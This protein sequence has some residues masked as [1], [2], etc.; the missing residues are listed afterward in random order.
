[1]EVQN[2]LMSHLKAKKGDFI[3][4]ATSLGSCIGLILYDSEN[5]IGGMAHIML[6]TSPLVNENN[7]IE[8]D[9]T[10][11]RYANKAIPTLIKEMKML[12]SKEN[13]ITAMLF[14]GSEMFEHIKDPSLKIGQ[15][16]I[17]KI[18]EIL[19]EINIPIV[20]EDT[21]G[22]KGRSVELN[23]FNGKVSLND[24]KIGQKTV[25]FVI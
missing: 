24:F 5:K 18:K 4:R 16:N 19:S 10:L 22:K 11:G 21:G 15:K 13:N 25:S 1:M 3:L 17:K 8:Q 20:F 23:C 12:G 14:G 9:D 7:N 6:P 2:I